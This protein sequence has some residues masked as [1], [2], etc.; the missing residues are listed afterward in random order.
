[1][2]ADNRCSRKIGGKS[3]SAKTFNSAGATFVIALMNRRIAAAALPRIIEE[4]ASGRDRFVVAISGPPGAGKSTLAESL[5][6]SLNTDTPGI[7][8]VI[9][10]DGF[11]FDNAILEE[12]NLLSRKGAPETFDV[13]GFVALLDRLRNANE[14]IA[15]P[16]FDRHLDLSRAGARIVTPSHRILIVEGN[17][18][19]LLEE[20]WAQL[21]SRFDVTCRLD[22][23]P[24]ELERRLVQ[25]WLDHGY[26]LPEARNRALS[27]DL[28]NA[29]RVMANSAEADFVLAG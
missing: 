14:D 1:M 11:H 2:L 12:R 8:V 6:Q 28:P 23:R 25:R 4:R 15:I 27:N 9:P 17:Y 5:F 13:A 24:D 19:L 10:M 18:L 21:S 20:P 16:T 22:V 26:A 7:A 3:R 29:H